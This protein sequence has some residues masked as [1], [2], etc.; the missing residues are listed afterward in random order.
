MEMKNT[1]NY[2]KC[3]VVGI[4][5]NSKRNQMPNR[6]LIFYIWLVLIPRSY[7]VGNIYLSG[8][9]GKRHASFHIGSHDKLGP[10]QKART[11]FIFIA[12]GNYIQASWCNDMSA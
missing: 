11:I 9:L 2:Q 7:I 10:Y 6:D 1:S 8:K 5:T 3:Y 4:S 12:Q